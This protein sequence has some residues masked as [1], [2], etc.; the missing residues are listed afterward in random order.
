MKLWEFA[1]RRPVTVVMIYVGLLALAGVAFTRLRIDLLPDISFPTIGIATTY[2]GAGAEEI[3]QK[4]TRIIE[5][6]VAITTNLKE[7]QS[8]SKEGISVVRLMF[9]WGT[10]LD[11]AA[12]D[13]RDKLGVL[14]RYLPEG[15][16]KPQI[17][18]F[19]LKDMPVVFL[20]ARANESY[21]R[22]YD[23]LNNEVSD[24]LKRVP[25]VGNVFVRGGFMRQVNI[26][27]DRQKLEARNL[28][29]SDVVRALASNNVTLPSGTMKI[30]RTEYLLR[31]LGEF[32]SI[33]QM[34]TVP[35]GQWEGRTVYLK[36][37]AE[38]EDGHYDETERV[39]INGEPG[40]MVLVQKRSEA[41]TVD[42]VRSIRER[43]PQIQKTLPAD[44][45]IDIL[46]D[47]AL[48]IQR[49]IDNL[50]RALRD[51]ALFVMLV[52]VFFLRKFRPAFIVLLSIPVSLIDSF[53][54]QY[55][56][57][58]TINTIS[59]MSLTIVV[60]MVVDDAIVV[61]ENQV[62]HQEELK[63]SPMEAAVRATGEVGRAVIAS[64]LTS[65]IV[66]LPIIFARGVAGVLFRQLGVVI[67][68]TLLLSLFDS[69]TLNPML[70]S[71]F[72][73]LHRLEKR[74]SSLERFYEWSESFFKGIE[75][76]YQNLI[77]YSLGHKKIVLLTA[78]GLLV[79]SL[80]LAPLV[81]T[82]FMPEQDA[83][84]IQAQ[85]ELPVGTRIEATNAVFEEADMI[86]RKDIAESE[87][88]FIFWR[89]GTNP[90]NAFGSM[91][92]SKSGSH[93]GSL[94]ARLVEKDKRERGIK[95]IN[96]VLRKD[97]SRIPGIYRVGLYTGDLMTHLI[98]G[99]DKPLS[100][101]IVGYDMDASNRIAEQVS[102]ILESEPGVRDVEISRDISQP[103]I[104]VSMD[105]EKAGALGVPVQTVADTM[106]IAFGGKVAGIYREKGNDYDIFVRFRDEDRHDTSD[107]NE[108]WVRSTS[109]K[110][111]P[112]QNLVRIGVG[113]GPV[114][115]E[116][117]EQQRIVRVMANT[118]GKSLGKIAQ[119]LEPKIKKVPLPPAFHI[120]MGGF[121]KEQREAFNDLILVFL[122][123]GMLTYMIMASQ[124]ESLRDPFIIMF[125]VP[126][127]IVGVIWALF[128]TGRTVNVNSFIGIIM[129]V[130][131]VVKNAIVYLDYALQLRRKGIGV[132]EALKEAGRVRLRPI[133][134]TTSAMLLGLLPM[135]L[136]QGQGS[137][138]WQ[139]MSIA[140]I[141]GLIVST[142]VTLVLVPVLYAFFESRW[143][144][145][146]S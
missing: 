126:F 21:P 2:E 51:G 115:I 66:F 105:R 56:F 77:T 69:F 28:T 58:Y 109:G 3:E 12:N 16:E 46:R 70:S 124:F 80:A 61:M 134:M 128:L 106:D 132:T 11:A 94:N 25:G 131:I 92:G 33:D 102:S 90:K 83:G 110:L 29:A 48:D 76:R 78:G 143:P 49:N 74:R 140:V 145:D 144:A 113:K 120:E 125:S 13:V 26:K 1:V 82:E 57:G 75:Q 88:N 6:T 84:N 10:D 50:A 72:L 104:Q 85:I 8:V 67:I 60:G 133:L 114:Q 63:E 59:L 101:D 98:T 103:E 71:R 38:V 87:R 79:F 17:F 96:E 65:V 107:I 91:M 20:G 123:A 43:L 64:T 32:T 9:E 40:A 93:V 52:I 55:L 86:M 19:D 41:N 135:A 111:I 18:R 30:A 31:A 24:A 89:D 97:L 116:R 14:E 138:Q 130:G 22:L 122:L 36:D 54:F 68:I 62:R 127:G 141:G 23:L 47:N 37:V 99:H 27:I 119:S 117:D 146:Y 5:S 121:V 44:V 39:R 112:L 4:V 108:T 15:T 73:I 142:L 136:S 42:V 118:Y 95:E 34:S 100:V 35:L 53:L 45:R 137:E 139:A 129:M 81:G 7:I